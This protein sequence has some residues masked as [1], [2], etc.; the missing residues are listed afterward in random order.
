MTVYT[1]FKVPYGTTVTIT[2]LM[3]DSER[4]R[5]QRQK[6]AAFIVQKLLELNEQ[7]KLEPIYVRYNGTCMKFSLDEN[8]SYLRL[9]YNSGYSHTAVNPHGANMEGQHTTAKMFASWNPTVCARILKLAKKQIAD[10][11]SL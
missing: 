10:R 6:H 4:K 7:H 8:V 11:R 2:R 3:T 9:T 5:D 1:D